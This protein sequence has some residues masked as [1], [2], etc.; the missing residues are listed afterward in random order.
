MHIFNKTQNGFFQNSTAR[1]L[2]GQYHIGTKERKTAMEDIR[3]DYSQLKKLSLD[4]PPI[5]VKYSFFRP[6][7]IAPLENDTRLSLCEILRKAQAENRCICGEPANQKYKF[8]PK[9]GKPTEIAAGFKAWEENRGNPVTPE[10]ECV[11]KEC[12]CGNTVGLNQ[13]LCYECGRKL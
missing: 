7:G 6:E 12:S 3:N 13:K 5:G 11:S 8:C 10:S 1:K 2:A 4:L 9:C